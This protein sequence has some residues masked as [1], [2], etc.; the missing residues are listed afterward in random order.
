[1]KKLIYDIVEFIVVILLFLA[2]ILP[3]STD[4]WLPEGFIK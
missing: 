1:M 3:H 4:F 2:L